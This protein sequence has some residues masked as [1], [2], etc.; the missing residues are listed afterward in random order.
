ME[1]KETAVD[2]LVSLLNKKGFAPVVMEE[3]IKQA[4]EIEKQRMLEFGS[5]VTERWGLTKVEEHYIEDE[6]NK[7][8]GKED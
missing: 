7:H 3:E 5:K 4:K 1:N 8:Y 2:W 6:Y